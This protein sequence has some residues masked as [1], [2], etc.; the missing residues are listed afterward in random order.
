MTVD[1]NRFSELMMSRIEYNFNHISIIR[2]KGNG[3][4]NFD[5]NFLKK[6]SNQNDLEGS[7]RYCSL[8]KL[9]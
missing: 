7:T 4:G 5:A 3:N 2:R 6:S 9:C 8:L 1:L